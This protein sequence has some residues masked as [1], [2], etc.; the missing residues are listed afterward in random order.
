MEDWDYIGGWRKRGVEGNGCWLGSR[1]DIIDERI[2]GEV[3]FIFD[4][5][6]LNLT[7]LFGGDDQT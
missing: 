1:F 5:W 4:R 6:I 7:C 3:V 2:L